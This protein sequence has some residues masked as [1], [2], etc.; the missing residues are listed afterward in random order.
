MILDEIA[1]SNR[2]LYKNKTLDFDINGEKLYESDNPF[3]FEKQLKKEGMS[4]ICECK[5][6]SP[7]KGV[8]AKDYPYVEIAKSYEKAGASCISVLTEP[9]YFKGSLK[10]LKEVCENVNIPVIRKDF[11][12]NS[13]MIYEAKYYGA[14]AVLLICAILDDNKLK[15][16][17]NLCDKLKISALVEAHD[18]TE[19]KRAINAGARIIGV[20]NRNLKDFTVD[21]NNAINLRK[22]VP[23]N[24]VFVAESGIKNSEDIKRLYDENVDAVL[25]GETLMKSEDKAKELDKLKELIQ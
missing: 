15:E 13:H 2:E 20:N 1:N 3:Y 7:S 9:K 16:Y 19:V 6:A 10:H 11:V 8:I 25:I 17:I 5:S 22:E 12:I 4:F 18:L 24:I 14:E 23:S 21:F